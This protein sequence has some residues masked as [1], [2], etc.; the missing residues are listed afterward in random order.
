[1]MYNADSAFSLI[2][3]QCRIPKI[4]Q[5]VSTDRNIINSRGRA[6][7]PG[8][9]DSRHGNRLGSLLDSHQEQLIAVTSRRLGC[10]VFVLEYVVS[11]I[12]A[13]V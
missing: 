11:A 3:S 6:R 13:I 5:C 4:M 9:A 2:P 7:S 1:M 8:A 12:M 10:L